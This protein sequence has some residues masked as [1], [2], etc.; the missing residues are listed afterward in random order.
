MSKGSE[1]IWVPIPCLSQEEVEQKWWQVVTVVRRIGWVTQDHW[2]HELVWLSQGREGT[3]EIICTTDVIFRLS[4][5]PNSLLSRI[6]CFSCFLSRFLGKEVSKYNGVIH[7]LF[8]IYHE[9]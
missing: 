1:D 3:L 4:Q 6:T 2:L 8:L 9:A 7:Q 5:F